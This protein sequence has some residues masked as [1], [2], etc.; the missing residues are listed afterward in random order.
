MSDFCV[1]L[2]L[3]RY[4]D[5]RDGW[6]ASIVPNTDGINTYRSDRV[7]LLNWDVRVVIECSVI[8]YS[9]ADIIPFAMTDHLWR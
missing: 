6:D 8:Q 4:A 2:V 1:P 7:S 3:D 5:H 9:V